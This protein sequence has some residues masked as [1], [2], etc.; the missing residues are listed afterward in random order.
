VDKKTAEATKPAAAGLGR[1]SN[2]RRKRA[3]E[4]LKRANRRLAQAVYIKA[5]TQPVQPSSCSAPALKA[6][7][8]GATPK[9]TVSEIE[10]YSNPKRLVTRAMRAAR[11]SKKSNTIATK[12]AAAARSKSAAAVKIA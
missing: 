8:A 1:P 2:R 6:I 3:G 10:S 4:T 5:S 7:T 11:P 12:I 9:E